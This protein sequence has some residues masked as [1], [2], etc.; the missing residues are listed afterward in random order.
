MEDAE[1]ET[2]APFGHEMFGS[3]RLNLLIRYSFGFSDRG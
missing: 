2:I 1:S 3:G